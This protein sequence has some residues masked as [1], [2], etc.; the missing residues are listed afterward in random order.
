MTQNRTGG[1]SGD[2]G[3][4]VELTFQPIKP[5][6]PRMNYTVKVLAADVGQVD[7]HVRYLDG[8]GKLLRETDV[9]WQNIMAG[10]RRPIQEGQCYSDTHR[11][12]E[13]TVKAETQLLRVTFSDGRSWTAGKYP[14][15]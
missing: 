15:Q 4:P 6:E 5:G 3:A 11:F 13:G 14:A 9:A 1:A 7:F 12:P 10:E 2:A 8:D